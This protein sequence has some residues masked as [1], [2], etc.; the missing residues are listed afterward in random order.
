VR[1][2]P[3]RPSLLGHSGIS[4]NIP[5]LDPSAERQRRR[6]QA[7]DWLLDYM[8]RRINGSCLLCPWRDACRESGVR[9]RDAANVQCTESSQA[10]VIVDER[11]SHLPELKMETRTVTRT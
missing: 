3:C 8:R 6:R 5:D 9:T 4:V 1:F 11:Q 2:F 10:F 7:G